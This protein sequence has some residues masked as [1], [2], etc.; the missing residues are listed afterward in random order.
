MVCSI[1][2]TVNITLPSFLPDNETIPE[3][4]WFSIDGANY[5]DV[6][7]TTTRDTNGT[8]QLTLL[9]KDIVVDYNVS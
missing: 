1:P 6:N 9:L 8:A 5:E 4:V 7:Y 3:R 2:F